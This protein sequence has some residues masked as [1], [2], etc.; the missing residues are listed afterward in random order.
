MP[1][2]M[3]PTFPTR[4]ADTTPL[5]DWDDAPE[6][7]DD[8]RAR[9][10]HDKFKQKIPSG[11]MGQW[12]RVDAVQLG[13]AAGIILYKF[14]SPT[15]SD[16]MKAD[17]DS[18]QTRAA[19]SPSVFD[20]VDVT[21]AYP[22]RVIVLRGSRQ[23]MTVQERTLWALF[24][25]IDTSEA[26]FE[27]MRAHTAA[28]IA[29][30]FGVVFSYEPEPDFNLGDTHGSAKAEDA[31]DW[32]DES[33]DDEQERGEGE[34]DDDGARS[35]EEIEYDDPDDTGRRIESTSTVAS[36][37]NATGP[38]DTTII[39][40][41]RVCDNCLMKTPDGPYS[42]YTGVQPC[43]PC[44]HEKIR[45]SLLG[46]RGDG[47]VLVKRLGVVAFFDGRCFY[48]LKILVGA[49]RAVTEGYLDFLL[50][51]IT[52]EDYALTTSDP[53]EVPEKV[54]QLR[55]YYHRA[56]SRRIAWRHLFLE[57]PK[58][59]IGVT[60]AEFKTICGERREYVRNLRPENEESR[61]LRPSRPQ[62]KPKTSPR[63]QK[64]KPAGKSKAAAG[65]KRG[66]QVIELSDNEQPEPS[67][68]TRRT[69]RATTQ[70]ASKRTAPISPPSTSKP[71]KRFKTGVVPFV[72]VP[73]R[74]KKSGSTRSTSIAFGPP[75][76]SQ[77][78]STSYAL[79][80]PPFEASTSLFGPPISS[81]AS[82]ATR[83]AAG[84]PAQVD[85]SN[86]GDLYMAYLSAATNFNERRSDMQAAISRLESV[87]A[88]AEGRH[89]VLRNRFRPSGFANSEEFLTWSQTAG[90]V[91]AQALRTNLP[92]NSILDP[93]VKMQDVVPALPRAAPS[94]QPPE[95]VSEIPATM[96]AALPAPPSAALAAPPSAA[97]A[98]SAAPAAPPSAAPAAPPSAAPAAP[99]SA[100]PAAPPSAA[101]PAPTPHRT[102]AE[103]GTPAA[104]KQMTPAKEHARKPPGKKH[105]TPAEQQ[106]DD[107]EDW[108]E[109]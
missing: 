39:H 5:R 80:Q 104:E 9:R 81:F 75:A 109:D 107:D 42:C 77:A 93:D 91:I 18:I 68:S 47:W 27:A 82:S 85:L 89:H 105:A 61:A 43:G 98:A 6:P 84:T 3:P 32:E 60:A 22:R 92:A 58:A 41:R 11:P 48:P 25:K 88:H 23:V 99:P 40:F 100:A 21:T 73:A 29:M 1:M 49:Q 15:L 70:A 13:K 16:V 76:S 4:L 97:L 45:C 55:W 94:M 54:T 31:Q 10:I 66:Q 57:P 67:T 69:T 62:P 79:F 101:L 87:A 30:K 38:P 90:I 12:K 53:V 19:K 52:K 74:V 37:E 86:D 20:L 50:H 28:S 46:I 106:E 96:P 71:S 78:S 36:L 59:R 8:E 26:D 34:Q 7:I 83:S 95:E 33:D 44:K 17:L 56:D 65:P 35:G 103:R 108:L 63:K 64:P 24:F 51:T 102:Q 72:D 14:S 2:P